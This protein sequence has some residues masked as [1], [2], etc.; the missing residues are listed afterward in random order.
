MLKLSHEIVSRGVF[1]VVLVEGV[2]RLP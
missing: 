1:D 2:G